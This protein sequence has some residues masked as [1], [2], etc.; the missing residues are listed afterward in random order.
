MSLETFHKYGFDS[1]IRNH[2][3]DVL[4]LSL[5][6]SCFRLFKLS[7]FLYYADYS[8]RINSLKWAYWVK[9]WKGLD[10]FKALTVNDRIAFWKVWV[11][12][13]VADGRRRIWKSRLVQMIK[14]LL[15]SVNEYGL[16]LEVLWNWWLFLI[17]GVIGD[18][19][20]RWE[21]V[22]L[23]Y[24]FR[25][26]LIG[27]GSWVWPWN[28]SRLTNYINSLSSLTFVDILA[29]YPERSRIVKPKRNLLCLSN[30]VFKMIFSKGSRIF[31]LLLLK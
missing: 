11:S 5:Q 30:Y 8:P 18:V 13:T 22:D 16:Y 17:F 15:C 6:F 26:E 19:K 3:V 24:I 12:K 25:E 10:Y 1:C 27:L 4:Y 23:K 31:F 7:G 29:N 14:G 20:S 9:V 21:G 2:L 28:K